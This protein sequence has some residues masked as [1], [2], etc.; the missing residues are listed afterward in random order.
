MTTATEIFVWIAGSLITL[1]LGGLGWALNEIYGNLKE[2][3]DKN[4]ERINRQ[5]D[6]IASTH[7]L[8]NDI[9]NK[10]EKINIKVDAISIKTDKT[11]QILH[12]VDA[13]GER[14]KNTETAL[15]EQQ[16]SHGRVI[17]VLKKLIRVREAK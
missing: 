5:S 2:K 9:S 16:E 17:Q 8:A 1:L 10:Q 4:A 13:I 15:K 3:I 7:S 11:P 14:I 6:K 12:Q